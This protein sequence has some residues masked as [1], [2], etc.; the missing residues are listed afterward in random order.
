MH[1]DKT[2]DENKRMDTL[3][4]KHSNHL[5]RCELRVHG[6]VAAHTEQTVDS[7]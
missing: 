6:D 2:Q 3:R 7:V 4:Y 1:V 5:N